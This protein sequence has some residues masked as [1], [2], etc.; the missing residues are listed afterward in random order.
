MAITVNNR[1][2]SSSTTGATS[3]TIAYTPS[4][5]SNRVLVVRLS[6][7]RLAETDFTATAK[8]GTTGNGSSGTSMTEAVTASGNAASRWMRSYIFYLVNPGT[9]AGEVY[10]DLGSVSNTSG[11]VITIETLGGV[12]QT[13]PLG[14]TNSA[15]GTGTGAVTADVANVVDGSL[16]LAVVTAQAAGTTQSYTWSGDVTEDYDTVSSNSTSEVMG[17]GASY[18]VT[19]GDT[20]AGVSATRSASA[21]RH[22]L[23]AAEFLSSGNLYSETVTDGLKYGEPTIAGRLIARST[24]TD[25]IKKGDGFGGSSLTMRSTAT[26]GYKFG[27]ATIAGRLAMR[28]LTTDGLKYGDTPIGNLRIGA[29]VAE[30]VTA[31]DTAAAIALMLAAVSDGVKI[32]DIVLSADANT[33]SEAV[34]D[35]L[36]LADSATSRLAAVAAVLDGAKFG[37]TVAG[38]LRILA[39]IADSLVVSESTVGNLHIMASI[40]EGIDYAEAIGGILSIIASV[41]DGVKIGDTTIHLLPAGVVRV[42]FTNS[43]GV[44]EITFSTG[45]IS[46]QKRG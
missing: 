14:D 29:S 9:S 26:D 17:S 23:V 12:H 41:N 35:G 36:V 45:S 6:L 5:V 31:G 33:Y 16:V 43:T 8:F 13:T 4:N 25:G 32:G 10:I 19:G 27:E 34:T 2:T 11:Y 24:V 7:M 18:L 22:V 46:F 30:G 40:A 15:S 38:T 44:V 37:D 21:N 1:V 39:T 42:T 20:T 3:Y 28:M